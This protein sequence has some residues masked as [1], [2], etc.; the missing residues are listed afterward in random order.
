M[1]ADIEKEGLDPAVE[2]EDMAERVYSTKTE[3]KR[4]EME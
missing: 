2:A 3:D 1:Y 4:E